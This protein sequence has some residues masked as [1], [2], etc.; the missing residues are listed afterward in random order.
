MCYQSD[1]NVLS[2]MCS[3]NHLQSLNKVVLSVCMHV[4]L[5]VFS[6]HRL[7]L[8]VSHTLL[9]VA[10]KKK[11]KKKKSNK[12]TALDFC[13]WQ[14]TR[15]QATKKQMKWKKSE[16]E[17]RTNKK[18]NLAAVMEM[19]AIFTYYVHRIRSKPILFGGK[20]LYNLFNFSLSPCSLLCSHDKKC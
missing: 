8:I 2:S 4:F 20:W 11:K 1:F 10:K 5:S 17:P 14:H 6:S 19:G 16:A 13:L 12:N 7:T 9:I 18:N 3:S 15:S